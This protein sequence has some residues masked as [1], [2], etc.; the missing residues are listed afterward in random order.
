MEIYGNVESIKQAIQ[1]KFDDDIKAADNEKKAQIEGIMREAKEKEEL[2]SARISTMT[3]SEV[4]KA[5]SKIKSEEILKAKTE[6]EQKREE[7]ID[8]IFEMAIKNARKLAHEKGYIEMVKKS[9]PKEQHY[10]LICDSDAYKRSFPKAKLKIDKDIIGI[11][12][13]AGDVTYDFTIDSEIKSKKDILRNK[14][15]GVLFS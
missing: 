4:K 8:K 15:S 5:T 12:V 13:L 6:F 7:I 1:K 14:I 9:L 3:E 11:K 10:E 2:I